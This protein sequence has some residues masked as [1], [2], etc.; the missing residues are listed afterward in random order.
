MAQFI[1]CLFNLQVFAE[2]PQVIQMEKP[3]GF[4]KLWFWLDLAGNQR[5]FSNLIY[6][7]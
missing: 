6:W 3:A 2:K 4:S 1:M 7:G 5:I